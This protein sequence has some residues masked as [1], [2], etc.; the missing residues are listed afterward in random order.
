MLACLF[1]Y[2]DEASAFCAGEFPA[3]IEIAQGLF[4]SRGEVESVLGSHEFGVP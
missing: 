3:E 2:L 4:H 1:S